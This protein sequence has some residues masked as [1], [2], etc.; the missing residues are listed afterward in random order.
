MFIDIY[1]HI[2]PDRFFQE[3]QK[4]SP[5]LGNIGARLRGVKKLFDLDARFSEMDEFG[6]YRE[7]ISLPNPPI[8]DL[9]QGATAAAKP[10]KRC[11]CR[12]HSSAMA[13]LPTRASVSAVLPCARSSIGGL[14]RLMI[15]R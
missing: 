6:D 11:G 10:G 15:S 1:C 2:Y 4:V 3:M 7:I 12:A 13:S 9:A 14:G 5:R 8:E